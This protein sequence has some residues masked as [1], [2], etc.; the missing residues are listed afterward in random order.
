MQE[1]VIHLAVQ[2]L[3]CIK[4]SNQ[5]ENNDASNQRIGIGIYVDHLHCKAS[6][7]SKWYKSNMSL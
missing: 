3:C 6:A 1:T 5:N 2:C 7:S 4:H